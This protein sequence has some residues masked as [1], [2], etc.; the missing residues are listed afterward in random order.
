MILEDNTSRETARASSAYDDDIPVSALAGAT[1]A[2]RSFSSPEILKLLCPVA[3]GV[4]LA[5]DFREN[6]FK[7]EYEAELP[8]PTMGIYS[9][10]TFSRSYMGR[11]TRE[12]LEL[13]LGW[14]WQ[15][16][17]LLTSETQPES[18]TIEGVIAAFGAEALAEVL[19][20]AMGHIE[21]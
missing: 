5:Q 10:K 6:R 15:K 14:L 8:G 13:V 18:A 2:T 7:G 1:R 11:T 3:P 12:A 16:H 17:I 19:S 20:P 21:R 4:T 9:Q